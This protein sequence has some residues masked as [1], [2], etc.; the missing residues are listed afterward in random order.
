MIS[1]FVFPENRLRL[2]H[3]LQAEGL[4]VRMHGYEF[5]VRGRLFV[6]TLSILPQYG[7]FIVRRIPWNREESEDAVKR[8]FEIIKAMDPKVEVRVLG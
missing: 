5:F 7:L 6:C 8:I 3:R 1:V 4:Q 2:L